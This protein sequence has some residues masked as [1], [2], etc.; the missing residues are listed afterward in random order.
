MKIKYLFLILSF[1]LFSNNSKSITQLQAFEKLFAPT[2]SNNINNEEEK[3]KIEELKR[4]LTDSTFVLRSVGDDN[5]QLQN[6]LIIPRESVKP[7][8]IPDLSQAIIVKIPV[9]KIKVTK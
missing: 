9:Q 6:V 1:V 5:T 2:G 7:N 4:I 8:T 3:I